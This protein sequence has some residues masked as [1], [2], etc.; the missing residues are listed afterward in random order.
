MIVFTREKSN[1]AREF[2]SVD[3]L[4]KA[5]KKLEAAPDWYAACEKLAV[6]HKRR[7]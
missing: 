7:A 6:F 2:W 4:G 3:P 5:L 1:N